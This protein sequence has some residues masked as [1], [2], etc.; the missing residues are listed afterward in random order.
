MGCCVFSHKTHVYL[1]LLTL[2]VVIY[3]SFCSKHYRALP[4]PNFNFFVFQKGIRTQCALPTTR[5]TSD[6]Q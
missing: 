1:Q 5:N 2:K 3:V 6:F 4:L